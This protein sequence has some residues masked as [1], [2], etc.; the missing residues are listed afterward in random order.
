MDKIEKNSIEITRY[1]IIKPFLKKQKNLK[2]ISKESD[3]SYSTLKRWVSAYKK[4]GLEGLKKNTRKDKNTFRILD[5]ETVEKIEEIYTENPAIKILDIYKLVSKINK[6]INYDTVYR[7]INN[8][9]PFVKKV[10]D[11]NVP[12]TKTSNEIFEYSYK[13]LNIKILDETTDELKNPFLH[14]IYD[15]FS[16][17][18]CS[19]YINFEPLTIEEIYLLLR[20]AI[21]KNNYEYDIYGKPK[22]FIINNQKVNQKN[23]F[24]EIEKKLNIKTFLC[25]ENENSNKD[26]YYELEEIYLK[27]FLIYENTELNYKELVKIVKNFIYLTY[28]YRKYIIWDKNLKQIEFIRDENI[29]NPLLIS[30]NSKRKVQIQGVRYNNLFYSNKILN[31]YIGKSITIKIDYNN[32]QYIKVYYNNNFLCIAKS[33]SFYNKIINYYEFQAIKRYILIKYYN[34]DISFTEFIKEFENIIKEY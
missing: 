29:L 32:M 6:N 21:L 24:L 5:T 25:Y 31:E 27:D 28:N 33:E 1:N 2:E 4:N 10:V 15:S 20:K 26:F 19:F 17:G 14:I 3:V 12:F 22:E 16:K 7:V 34:K 23:I 18:I 30:I 13:I 9:D 11:K 8:L